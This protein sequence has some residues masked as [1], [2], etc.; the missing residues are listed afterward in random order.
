MLQVNCSSRRTCRC[1][2]IQMPNSGVWTS[3]YCA[4]TFAELFYERLQQ[5]L[6]GQFCLARRCRIIA[7][8]IKD[9]MHQR[10]A[11][12]LCRSEYDR[13][14]N[15]FSPEGRLFQVEYAIEA[16]KVSQEVLLEQRNFCSSKN[17]LIK[18]VETNRCQWDEYLRCRLHGSEYCT[19]L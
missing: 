16:I 3:Y 12:H 13:G 5:P 18:I 17:D 14:V 2:V 8:Y 9:L 1:S 10:T 7:E 6:T 19:W 11:R 4:T 15:T